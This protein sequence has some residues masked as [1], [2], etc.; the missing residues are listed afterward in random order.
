MAIIIAAL[1]IGSSLAMTANDSIHIYG[2]PTLS[3]IGFIVSAILGI[4]LI[5]SSMK[6]VEIN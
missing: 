1:I 5:I 3:V 4:L 2:L 6:K